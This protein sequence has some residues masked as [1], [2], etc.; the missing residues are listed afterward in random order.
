M[1]SRI[2]TALLTGAAVGLAMLGIEELANLAT[3]QPGLAPS[4]IAQLLPCYLGWPAIMA[5]C[6]VSVRDNGGRVLAVTAA[7]WAFVIGAV[8]ALL[9]RERGLPAP[10]VVGF[11]AA[12]LVA[13]GATVVLLR[14]VKSA[15]TR[16]ALAVW[17]LV[18]MP[19]WRAVNL[20]AFGPPGEPAAL[21][22]D[23]LIMG[24]SL[25]LAGLAA[26]LAP[27]LNRSL[28]ALAAS[29]LPALLAIGGRVLLSPTPPV[30]A[31]ASDQPDLVLVVIDTLRADHLGSYG[32]SRPTSPALDELAARGLRYTDATSAAPWTLPSF[33]SLLTG[34]IPAHH[35]AGVNPGQHTTQAP[36]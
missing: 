29:A 24:I 18:F 19:A 36:L 13:V 31:A 27:R 20:N 8:A 7:V 3:A 35:G 26:G 6:A 2:F 34:L 10:A 23:A 12:G 11:L 22:A 17:A 25:L 28:W 21:R 32:Y 9:L 33:A 14:L 15:R 16:W 1:L 4:E 30:P 5:L